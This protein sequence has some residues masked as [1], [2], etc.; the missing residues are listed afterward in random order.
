MLFWCQQKMG[1]IKARANGSTF[2]E[3]SKKA[4]RPIPIL[5]PP[6]PIV[7]AFHTV[8]SP[9]FARMVDNVKQAQTLS[10]LRD[11]LLPRLITGQLRV[12]DAALGDG[13]TT[14]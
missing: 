2:M 1:V 3:I 7:E 14:H 11:L 6:A 4:F 13:L 9:L 12:P 5:V 10:A 8:A